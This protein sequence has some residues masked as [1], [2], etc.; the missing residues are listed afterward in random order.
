MQHLPN[1]QRLGL[2]L[3]STAAFVGLIWRL[4]SAVRIAPRSS[5]DTIASPRDTLLPYISDQEA[6]CLAY[7]PNLLPGG[8]DVPTPYGIMRVY[9]WGPVEGRKVVM[10]HGDATPCPMF[11]PIARKLVEHGCRVL[12]FGGQRRSYAREL[13]LT[14]SQTFGAE[15]TQTLLSTVN[16]TH[17]CI[18]CRSSLLSRPRLYLGQTLMAAMRQ[19]PASQ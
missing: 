11:L 19:C 18:A 8:R 5:R 15:A 7:P 4:R 1:A 10:V 3:V 13:G 6:A 9:E 14:R 12:T 16:T 2:A 17:V